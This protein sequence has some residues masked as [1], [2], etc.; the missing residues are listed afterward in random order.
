MQAGVFLDLASNNELQEIME[1]IHISI[2]GKTIQERREEQP[3]LWQEQSLDY[4]EYDQPTYE[5]KSR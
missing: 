2:H 4:S 5:R 1:N 3:S